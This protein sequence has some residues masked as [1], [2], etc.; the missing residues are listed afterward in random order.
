MSRMTIVLHLLLVWALL[1][2]AL[3]TVV[4]VCVARE[5][6]RGCRG[7][8]APIPGDDLLDLQEALSARGRGAHAAL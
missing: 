3:T 2:G 4:A 5:Y 7:T 6:L 8:G 1:S